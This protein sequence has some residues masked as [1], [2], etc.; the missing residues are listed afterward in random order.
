M[1]STNFFNEA[2]DKLKVYWHN[3]LERPELI[4]GIV[5]NETKDKLIITKTDE[6][7]AELPIE[8][9]WDNVLDK[10]TLVKS[11]TQSE[12]KLIITNLDDTT[13]EI[14]LEVLWN[15]IANKPNLIKDIASGEDKLTVT[16]TDD[17]TV[18]IPVS[19]SGGLEIR[20]VTEMDVIAP[21]NVV[22]PITESPDY[23][24]PPVEVL[25]QVPGETD[26][27]EVLCDFNAED[28]AKFEPNPFVAFDGSMYLKTQETF[29][30]VQDT[31]FT[32]GFLTRTTIDKTKLG[33]I[34]S[35]E[36]V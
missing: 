5:V 15:N 14:S 27:T 21:K 36:V 6:T 9:L 12:D 34:V 10:P 19:T 22:I 8:V 1:S 20:Q 3:I 18:D 23:A 32:E 29:P 2:T 33:E 25:K 7:T 30:S 16:F 11:V 28:A 26:K 17:T 4:K 35:I 13:L 24:L 31:S